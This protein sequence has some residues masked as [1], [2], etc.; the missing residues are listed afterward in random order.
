MCDATTE[1]TPPQVLCVDD[2]KGILRA[3]RRVLLDEDIE[4]ITANSGAEGLECIPEATNLALIISDQR[5]PEMTGVE[6]LQQAKTI[7][8][9]AYRVMLTGYA[10]I[11]ATMDAINKG[12]IWRYITKPWDDEQLVLLVRDAIRQ[13]NLEAENK[14]LQLIVEKQAQ[15]LKDWNERLKQRVLSQTNRIRE[16]HEELAI[17]NKSLRDSFEQTLGTLSGLIE[18]RDN[19]LRNHARN[20]A[21]IAVATAQKLNLSAEQQKNIRAAA[22]LQGIGKLGIPEGIWIK[23]DKERTESEKIIFASYPVRSQTAI[24]PIVD[25]RAAGVII[26][27]IMER[28]DGNGYPDQLQGEQIPIG[29]RI[30]SIAGYLDR[31]ISTDNSA[32]L[33]SIIDVCI[34]EEGGHFDLELLPVVADSARSYY[35]ESQPSAPTHSRRELYPEDLRCGMV[36]LRDV[37]SGTGLLLLKQGSTLSEDSITA[38]KRFYRTD[39]PKQPVLVMIKD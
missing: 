6:F 21:A 29:A 3:L 9:T 38:L 14:R 4:V 24:D 15:E 34:S 1:P 10:D 20:T 18:L 8:P 17:T 28:Y 39:T 16:K 33:E 26:R 25:L 31:N 12:E 32:S 23:P 35:S 22:L 5:M 2:E 7:C 19:K 11:N 37:Y 13:Y 36:V 27:H 30:I